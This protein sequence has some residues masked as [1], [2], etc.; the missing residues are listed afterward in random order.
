MDNVGL[1]ISNISANQHHFVKEKLCFE[2]CLQAYF[3]G[4]PYFRVFIS[5]QKL[6]KQGT[7]WHSY[8]KVPFSKV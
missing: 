8:K 1:L 7:V 2:P 6:Q 3:I 4:H 5:K